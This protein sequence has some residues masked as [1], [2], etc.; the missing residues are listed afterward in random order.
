MAAERL[1]I[2]SFILDDRR[3]VSD[4]LLGR[5]RTVGGALRLAPFDLTLD[6]VV[7]SRRSIA[8]RPGGRNAGLAG[9]H[10]RLAELARGASLAERADYRFSPHLTLGYRDG[11]P[12]QQR[13]APIGWRADELVLIHSY[14]G[15]TRHE[16][17]GRWPLCGD[18]DAGGQLSL[19]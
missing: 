18:E 4:E 8:L 3:A 1:H 5:L 19:W 7:G 6:R 13:I 11:E 14:L 10:R 17:V 9:L 16:V 12:F 15:R 2:T